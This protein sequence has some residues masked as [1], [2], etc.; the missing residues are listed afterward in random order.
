MT[1]FPDGMLQNL[2]SLKS[3][4]ISRF[5]KLQ[6]LCFDIL[7]SLGSLES[8][9]IMS[10]YELRCF[11]MGVLRGSISL[12]TIRIINCIKFKSYYTSS[13]VFTEL[14]SLRL[15]GGL[16]ELKS[17]PN[18]FKN[19]PSLRSL[20]LSGCNFAWNWKD[21][22]C[23]KLAV[24]PETIKYLSSL[25]HMSISHFPNLGSLPDSLGNL[26]SLQHLTIRD[27]P[28]LTYLPASIQNLSNLEGLWIVSCPNLMKKCEKEWGEEWHK[29]A[30]I[31]TVEVHATD[32]SPLFEKR[33]MSKNCCF[34]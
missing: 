31:P 19:L 26:T 3:L 28:K 30:H 10:C 2:N 22:P 27:C 15:F 12:K 5:T 17:D 6:E 7:I 11:Q 24:L 32:P 20:Y 16:S 21:Y 8:L 9:L 23:S 18:G 25:G 13:I 1:S 4:K 33:E 29:I 14:Q 34:N